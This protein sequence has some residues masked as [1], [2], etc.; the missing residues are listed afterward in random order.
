MKNPPLG[1]RPAPAADP[2]DLGAAQRVLEA[3]RE[4]GRPLRIGEIATAVGSHDNTVRGHLATLLER[5]LVETSTAPAEGRGRPAA[6]YAA[7]PRPGA[8]TDEYRS[9][10]GAFAADLVASGDG[11]QVRSRARRIGRS[12]GEGLRPSTTK[13]GPHE[14]L[15]AALADLGFGPRRDG[16]VVRLTTCPLLDLA[17]ANP[18]VICQVHLGLVDGILDRGEGDGEAELT[19]FAEPGAC[20]LR[21]PPA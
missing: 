14:R 9:L 10:A 18:D 12:W 6:L 3:L 11:P 19:P 13:G 15:D 1:P 16:D 4:A 2:G 8:R 5:G 21:T 17:V 7:G 20:L